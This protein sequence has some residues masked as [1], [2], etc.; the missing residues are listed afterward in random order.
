MTTPPFFWG[1]TSTFNNAHSIRLQGWPE[2][3]GSAGIPCLDRKIWTPCPGSIV[4]WL[5][6][7]WPLGEWFS[8]EVQMATSH[9][10]CAV[11]KGPIDCIW[12]TWKYNK[13]VRHLWSCHV[14][15]MCKPIPSFIPVF[16]IVSATTITPSRT[17]SIHLVW[18][19][20]SVC[21]GHL[22]IFRPLQKNDADTLLEI[23]FMFPGQKGTIFNSQPVVEGSL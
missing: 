5:C 3:G 11:S 9:F 16:E 17:S 18:V 13:F 15:W 4:P 12:S 8:S 6:A 14:T 1:Y 22:W 2:W 10:C 20:A 19:C 23:Y 7:P 21:R